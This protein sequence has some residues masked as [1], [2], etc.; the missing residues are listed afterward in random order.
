MAKQHQ[1]ITNHTSAPA[2][3]NQ[4]TAREGARERLLAGLPVT[5]RR[6]SLNG[7]PTAVLE[8]GDG[9][10]IVLLHGPGAYAAKWLRVIPDLVRTHRIIASD[11]PGH[12]S[13]GT[14]NRSPDQP[15]PLEQ[16][17]AFPKVL[18]AARETSSGQEVAR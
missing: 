17:D 9:R 1:R 13:S 7:V 12:G 11:L 5:E 14:F 15:P 10:P 16:P 18:C 6:L 2:R 8:G 4:R 3:R